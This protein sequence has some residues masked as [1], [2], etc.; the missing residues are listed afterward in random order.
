MNTEIEKY[1]QISVENNAPLYKQVSRGLEDFIADHLPGDK[2]PSEQ[3]LSKFFSINRETVRRAILE[4]VKDGTLVRNR[5]GTFI[6]G[7]SDKSVL[8]DPH[9]LIFQGATSHHNKKTLKLALYENLPNQKKFWNQAVNGFN[10]IAHDVEAGIDWV[11]QEVRNLEKYKEYIADTKPD[12]F[13]IG[14]LSEAFFMQDDLLADLP[15]NVEQKLLSDD[16]WNLNSRNSVPVHFAAWGIFWNKSLCEK[17]GL[18]QIGERIHSGQFFDILNEAKTAI[19]DDDVYVSGVVWNYLVS[20]GVPEQE[21]FDAR[22]FFQ[23]RLN[24]IKNAKKIFMFMEKYPQGGFDS[25]R[26]GK[27]IFYITTNWFVSNFIDSFKFPL[28]VAWS[29]P[30]KGLHCF[31]SPSSLGILKSKNIKTDAV[32]KFLDYLLSSH[33]QELLVKHNLNF[34]VLKEANRKFMEDFSCSSFE[35]LKLSCDNISNSGLANNMQKFLIYEIRD[36]YVKII[37]RQMTVE[38]ASKEAAARWKT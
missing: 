8:E 18:K 2:I 38:E 22:K 25:F 4:F 35:R 15:E 20:L 13:Q 36:L 7:A 28:G 30:E 5:K 12:V 14:G 26:D 27:S 10:R 37:K 16:Y 6:A 1:F 17:Y 34:A 33:T 23:E 24:R 9:P 29:I 32:S 19:K 11:P 31:S 3:A 21:N